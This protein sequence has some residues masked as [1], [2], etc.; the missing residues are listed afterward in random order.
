M[1]SKLGRGRQAQLI[2]CDCSLPLGGG[3][4]SGQR[5]LQITTIALLLL[6]GLTAYGLMALQERLRP[7]L[8][9]DETVEL[10][11]RRTPHPENKRWI[12][13]PRAPTRN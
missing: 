6:F 2:C 3:H 9:E 12:L 5:I 8:E 11:E 1:V 4:S 7:S 10:H 13:V